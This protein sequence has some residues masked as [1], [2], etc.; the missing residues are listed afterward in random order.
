MAKQLALTLAYFITGW[1][2]LK[3]PFIGTHITLIWLP[4][5]IAVAGLYRWGLR[6]WPAVYIGAWL[7]NFATGTGWPLA[8]AIAVGNTLGPLLSSIWLQRSDFHPAFDRQKD[9]G[10][11]VAAAFAGMMLPALGGVTSLYLAGGL[12]WDALVFSMLSWWLGDTVGVLLA[13]PLLLTLSWANLS[14]LHRARFEFALWLLTATVIAW[15]VLIHNY[16]DMGHSLPLAFLTIP[17]LTWA[18]LRFGN[19]GTAF[20]GLVFSAFAAWGTATGQGLFVLSDLRVSLF[21][22]WIYMAT[23]VLTGLL[24]TA[25]QAER[26]KMERELRISSD[27]LNNAQQIATIGSWRLDHA[28]NEL[29][30]SD[31][32]FRLLEIDAQNCRASEELFDQAIHPE[33]RDAVNR[34]HR[35][36]LSDRSPYEISHRL[37]MN[38][39]RVKWVHRRCR[40]EFDHAGKA[41]CSRGTLQDI[42]ELK[43]AE[44][45]LRK[46]SLAVEQSPS[47]IMITDLQANIEFANEAFFKVT[48]YSH[49]EAIGRNPKMLQSGKT[50][51]QTFASMWTALQR[52]ESW[53]GEFVNRRK[54]GSEYIETALISPLHH[55]GIV[56]HYLAIKEDVTDRKRAESALR[57]S[58][59]QMYSL[60]N[61]MAEGAFGLDSEGNCQFVN[62][63]FL[64]ILGYDDAAEFI[65]KPISPVIHHSHADG[66]PYLLDECPINGSLLHRRES[67]VSDEVFW[68]KN[69]E[70]VPVE[71]WSQPLIIDG[72]VNGAVATFIDISHRK[73]AEQAAQ[74]A[75]HYARGL[76]EASLDPLVTIS[77]EGK[78]TDVNTATEQATG[79]D[80]SA[81]IGS[82]FADYFTDPEQARA[83]YRLVFSQG[84]V[85]DY[86][87][88]MRHASGNVIEVLYNASVYRDTN[89]NV[90]GV[91]ATARD[92]TERKQIEA[93][94]TDSESR[95]RA[96]IENEPECIKLVDAE[97]CLLRMNPA[98][99][100][101]VE[102]DNHEQV[103]GQ[104]VIDLVAEEY[105]D[106]FADMH[107]RVLGGEAMQM[108]YEIVG[109]KGGRRW[110]ETHAVPMREADGTV[111]HLAVT[112]DINERKQAENELRIAATVFESQE[113]MMVTDAGQCILRVNKAFTDITGYTAE[114]V[115]GRNPNLLHSSRQSPEFYAAMW[116]CIQA[117]GE[118]SGEIWNRRKNGEVYPDY[119][120]ITAVKDKHG[121]VTHYVGT[122]LDITLRKAAAD[123]IERLAFYDPLTG[124]PNRRLLQNRLQPAFAASH[125]NGRKGALLF[126]DLDNFK[127]LNDSLGHDMGDLLLQQV[128]ERLSASVREGDTVARLGG[129]EFV[130]M[131]QDL[132]EQT[133]DA[134]KQAETIGNKILSVLNHPYQLAAHQYVNTPSIGA[135]LINGHETTVDEL[136]KH[137]DIAMYQAKLSGRNVLRFFDPQMQQAVAARYSLED[138]LRQAL[139]KQQFQLY[140]QVQVDRA[141]RALG[142][143]AL[144]RWRHP[145]RGLMAPEQFLAL[146]EETGLIVPLGQW[147]IETACAQLQAWQQS[148]H[149]CRLLLSVNISAKQFFQ[150]NFAARL[151]AAI[152]RHAVDPCL[153]ELELTEKLLFNNI[154][155]T[156]NLIKALTRIGVRLSLD[157]FG[158]GYSSLQHL[159]ALPLRRL[160]IDRSFVAGLSDN[161]R[162]V[163]VR[164]IVAMA[165]SLGLDVIAEG[166]ETEQQRQFLLDNGCAGFQGYLFGKPLTITRFNAMLA[167][168]DAR[169]GDRISAAA[170]NPDDRLDLFLP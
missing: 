65:G 139:D 146:A 111:V 58:H 122:H 150:T 130:V 102:A 40:T 61:S 68:S 158:T 132:S 48:G 76:I 72:E 5:G 94:L 97:G 96:I 167:A 82:D 103:A 39:G 59:Q 52:G 110:L 14:Q 67:H 124:L 114:E 152:E 162:Q 117:T 4:T 32:I 91:L 145:E 31:E 83:G 41:L 50:P 34:A 64:R 160:E 99:L 20:A 154:E 104:P 62:R 27:D 80:R 87:L 38:D 86:P 56:T 15:F 1:L 140:Y 123:E 121:N 89:G 55:N 45:S 21:V 120:T 109:L 57:E 113:G 131:L 73:Q 46:F 18:G 2:G 151:Q 144:I 44:E 141:G 71:Y 169:F 47:S 75:A 88:A 74:R 3:L 138:E 142:A 19:S 11:L 85:T 60:L 119:L 84:L 63:S 22:L 115:I 125:R 23:T 106:A 42:T 159:P 155:D 163:M 116:D 148:P 157:N 6:V 126:I 168:G 134:A 70:A 16:P 135:A 98:G 129:D 66:R 161:S 78:I 9:V 69:G 101:M 136:L 25:L 77:A 149:T 92:V 49:D 79:L 166:V 137:A 36:S 28:H 54:D 93:R 29:N 100:K 90:L 153:L 7:V 95:L 8:S 143:E 108:E 170:S 53:R 24:I 33:D 127:S 105:R 10:L 165:D 118:W 12:G 13:A 164:T 112:R 128:A 26:L 30:W 43:F 147:V 107:G 51:K 133:L 81:L 35:Q 17:L 37:L 156:L